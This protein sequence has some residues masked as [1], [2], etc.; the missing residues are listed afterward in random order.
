MFRLWRMS[1]ALSLLAGMMAVSPC[2]ATLFQGD[3]YYTH[4]TG[5]GPNVLKVGFTYN[6]VSKSLAYGGQIGVATVNGA[7]GIMFAPNG[8]LLVTSNTVGSVYRINPANGAVLQTIATSGST[9][10]HMAL[11]PSG[12]KF[13]SSDRYTRFS[14]PLD[15]F[16]INPN[17]TV[18]NATAT[19]IVGIDP[20]VTQLAFAPNGKVFYTDGT[21][22]ANGSIGLFTLG[23]PN[24]TTQLIGPNQVV[25]AHGIIYDPF[26]GLMTM[27]GGGQVATI[28]PNAGNN[29][30]ITNSLKQFDVPN[31]GDFDQGSVDGFG[32]AFIAGSG[33]ITFIDYSQSGDITNPNNT[34]IITGG[35]GNIDDVA[36]LVGLGAP[37]NAVPEPGSLTMLGIGALGALGF[38]WRRRRA[39]PPA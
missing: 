38:T 19:A 36:P 7:D 11:D 10:F 18:N 3:L 30:Q 24:S 28:D 16:V 35:F 32:H 39:T 23:N 15:T 1:G 9:D 20:N 4:F 37:P 17:G 5:G 25:A 31:I 29:T 13:Y 2:Q 27:F 33:A 12:T 22:N 8:N 21:P 6:D 14:G 26:T 34:I